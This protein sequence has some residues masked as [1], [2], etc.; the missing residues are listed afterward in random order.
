M[1]LK[2]LKS[3]MSKMRLRTWGH[4]MGRKPGEQVPHETKAWPKKVGVILS[5]EG[6][7]RGKD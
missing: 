1:R 5:P 7:C 4:V 2:I 6:C 3:L